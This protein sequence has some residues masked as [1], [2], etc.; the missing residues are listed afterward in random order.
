[1]LLKR[2]LLLCFLPFFL[3]LGGCGFK[4]IEP[5]GIEDIRFNKIDALLGIVVLDLGIKIN[6]PNSLAFTLYSSELDVKVGTTALGKVTVSEPV[7][8]KRK[9]QEVYRVKVNAK[10][11]DIIKN[12]PAIIKIIAQKQTDVEVKGWIRAGT[13]GLKKVIP[14]EIKQQQVPTSSDEKK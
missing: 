14:V 2:I 8:V 1:M 7:K 13:L 3:L 6:N 4:A 9:A 11:G 10:L 12:I 5:K